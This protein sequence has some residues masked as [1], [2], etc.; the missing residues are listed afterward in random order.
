MDR[1]KFTSLKDGM[2]VTGNVMLAGISS[3]KVAKNGNS[4]INLTLM[5]GETK[6]DISL[7]I[8]RDDFKINPKSV[9]EVKISRNGDYYNLLE[10]KAVNGNYKDYIMSAPED[11]E[12][13]FGKVIKTLS[14]LKKQAYPDNNENNT[15]Y[16]LSINCLSQYKEKILYYPASDKYNHTYVGG[17]I[18][19]IYQM[20]QDAYNLSRGSHKIDLEVVASAVC[21]CELGKLYTLT[22]DDMG[23]AERGLLGY[24]RNDVETSC[25]MVEPIVKA[26]S[27]NKNKVSA[28]YI[29]IRASRSR[30]QW[31][32]TIY[33]VTEEAYFVSEI[34]S[35]CARADIYETVKET[36]EYGKISEYDDRLGHPVLN[37]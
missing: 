15:L 37:I 28:L 30:K 33:P 8:K 17:M 18:Y 32:A 9:L 34:C 22:A 4:F 5:D 6:K 27:Y 26:G 20:L 25:N 3:E 1:I 13:L 12:L 7:F 2:T 31:G 23:E 35:I 21:L 10:Y 29:A 11:S 19:Y 36:L 14:A 24:I 16:D